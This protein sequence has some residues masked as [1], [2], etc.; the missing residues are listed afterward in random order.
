MPLEP[1]YNDT[2]DMYFDSKSP[3]LVDGQITTK[4]AEFVQS[5]KDAGV[6]LIFFMKDGS[7]L[8]RCSTDG[9]FHGK[10]YDFI[11]CLYY[12]YKAGWSGHGMF[13][14]LFDPKDKGWIPI[15]SPKQ[16]C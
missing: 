14:E 4:L 5:A 6:A 15:L 9:F 2:V 12:V 1:S 7:V 3:L 16:H 8:A 11:D 10:S 13:R